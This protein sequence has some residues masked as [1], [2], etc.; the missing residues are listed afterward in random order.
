MSLSLSQRRVGGISSILRASQVASW[1]GR[2]KKEIARFIE[3]TRRGST[4]HKPL[5][6]A[7]PCPSSRTR[8]DFTA[9]VVIKINYGTILFRAILTYLCS[10]H[11]QEG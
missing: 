8:L 11:E 7:S 2:I 9:S 5:L 1:R 4:G 10:E 3:A 6:M